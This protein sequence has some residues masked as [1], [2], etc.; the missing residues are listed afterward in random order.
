VTVYKINDYCIQEWLY[1]FLM[2]RKI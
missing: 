1:I 2:F